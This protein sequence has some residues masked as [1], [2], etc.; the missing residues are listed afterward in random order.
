VTLRAGAE[1]DTLV[2]MMRRES[3]MPAVL[4]L[5]TCGFYYFYWQY[6]TTDE[7][8]LAT[9]RDD[10]NPMTDLIITLLCCGVWAIYVQYRNA[11]I[12]HE[13]LTARGVHHDDK[14]T[15]ILIMHALSA[16]NGATGLVA[17]VMLQ[18]EFNKLADAGHGGGYGGPATF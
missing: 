7:L 14:S 15:I 1:I 8:R 18:D 6:V 5:V 12:V 17:I 3:W 10:I 9:G 4:T 2:R 13:T 11:Q 16:L